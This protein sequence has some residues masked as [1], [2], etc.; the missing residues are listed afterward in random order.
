MQSKTAQIL[1]SLSFESDYFFKE[2]SKVMYQI[3]SSSHNRQCRKR[4]RN[5]GVVLSEQGWQKLAQA[6]VLHDE[7][8][9]RYTHGKLSEQSLLNDRTISRILSCEIKVD[10]RTLKI[11]FAAFGLRLD[12]EDYTSAAE[13]SVDQLIPISSQYSNLTVCPVETNLS[14]QELTELYQRLKRDLKR[15][16][17]LLN[18]DEVSG[19]IQLQVTELN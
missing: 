4:N 8:G 6:G 9:N 1:H 10:K 14:R 15:L 5:R 19:G 17:H 11:F 12:S 16:A 2:R 13:R 3:S 7:W 18:L